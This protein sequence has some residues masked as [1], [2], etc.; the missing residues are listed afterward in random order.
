M[1]KILRAVFLWFLS[2]NPKA[3]IQDLKFVIL[4]ALCSW[5]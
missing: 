2:D 5:R 3:K 1:T 4:G